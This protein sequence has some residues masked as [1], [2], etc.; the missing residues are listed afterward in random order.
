MMLWNRCHF[1]V[2]TVRSYFMYKIQNEK[3][4]KRLAELTEEVGNG[5]LALAML[6]LEQSMNDPD[7]NQAR[8]EKNIQLVNKIRASAQS[9]SFKDSELLSKPAIIKIGRL[10]VDVIGDEIKDKFVGWEDSIERISAKL[11]NIISE[12]KNN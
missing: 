2:R 7:P 5:E 3:T 1:Y 4:Q 9:Q 8:I 12:T 6:L 10:V 11:L